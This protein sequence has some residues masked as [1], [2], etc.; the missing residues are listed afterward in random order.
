MTAK[1]ITLYLFGLTLLIHSAI[2]V[3]TVAGI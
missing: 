3:I 1:K 2:L